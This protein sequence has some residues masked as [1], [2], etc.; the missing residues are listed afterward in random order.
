MIPGRTFY[1][2]QLLII[3]AL[4]G[5]W[6]AGDER[7]LQYGSTVLYPKLLEP[8]VFCNSEFFGL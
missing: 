1:L 3:H 8:G 6:I 5:L 2:V 7:N 4:G